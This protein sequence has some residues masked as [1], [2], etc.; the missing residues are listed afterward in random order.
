MLA[1]VQKDRDMMNFLARI[2]DDKDFVKKNRIGY[3]SRVIRLNVHRLSYMIWRQFE[4]CL[5]KRKT[6][7]H[8]LLK[9]F[10]DPKVV[11]VCENTEANIRLEQ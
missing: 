7:K 11:E 1:E 10:T 8:R 9:T 6:L 2:R 5:Q 3:S 4:L